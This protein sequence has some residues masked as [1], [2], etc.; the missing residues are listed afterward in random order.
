LIIKFVPG[1]DSIVDQESVVRRLSKI[2]RKGNIPHAL[3]FTG[4]DGVGKR[5]T[6]K[7][8]AMAC[9]C[10][11][12][13]RM[14]YGSD[15]EKTAPPAEAMRAAFPC[16]ECRACRKIDAELHPDIIFIQPQKGTIKI[17]QIRDLCHMLAMK[18]YEAK[19]RVVII[20]E[21]HAMNPEAGNALLKLLEEPPG[22]TLLILTAPHSRNILPTIISR[23]QHVRF[24]PISQQT[25]S[26][27]LIDEYGFR[28]EEAKILS[29]LANGSMTKAR[30][31]VETGWIS[32]RDW[33]LSV[34]GYQ[35]KDDTGVGNV[36]LSLAFSER[37]ARQ[38]DNIPDVLDIFM[39]WFRDL[40]IYPLAP[41]KIINKDLM[42]HIHSISRHTN[43]S[44]VLSKFETVLKA[45]EMIDGNANPRLT[46]D[47]MMTRLMVS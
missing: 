7:V 21:A 1:F 15:N 25:L 24:K 45:R 34:L 5:K 16:G 13:N 26:S 18:P 22:R 41:E 19:Q 44:S 33:I 29:A 9:N 17:S 36:D 47:V 35:K 2:N 6:A 4:L 20:T 12:S 38:K 42:D 28:S 32:Q 10:M 30:S 31:L 14:P 43:T 23:C 39:A 3:L 8:F 46:L 37:I 27:F 40:M 11:C